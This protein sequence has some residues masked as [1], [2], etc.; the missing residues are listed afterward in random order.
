M[1]IALDYDGTYTADPDLWDAFVAGAQAKVH[2]VHMV[3]MRHESEP[4]RT[5]VMMNRIHYTDRKGKLAYMAAKGIQVQI[6]IDDQPRFILLAAT[7]RALEQVNE[8]PLD[9]S[10]D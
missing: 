2:E 4:V 6:W 10:A 8:G 9:W 5:G 1:I 7:P 3:T